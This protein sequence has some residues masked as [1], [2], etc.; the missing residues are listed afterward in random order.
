MANQ[1]QSCHNERADH[2]SCRNQFPLS[3]VHWKPHSGGNQ[4]RVKASDTSMNPMVSQVETGEATN[5]IPNLESQ[6][7]CH[8][9]GMT[10]GED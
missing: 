4:S 5:I 9:N 6:H 2:A 3:L 7:I 8:R 1:S 10:W